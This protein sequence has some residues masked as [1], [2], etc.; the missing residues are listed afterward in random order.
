MLCHKCCDAGKKNTGYT[1]NRNKIQVD[2]VRQYLVNWKLRVQWGSDYPPTMLVI[3]DMIVLCGFGQLLWC[4]IDEEGE[5]IM[6][7]VQQ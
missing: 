3:S 1:S 6:K 4:S 7:G 2:L 5:S